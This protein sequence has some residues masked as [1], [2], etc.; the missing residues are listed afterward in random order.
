MKTAAQALGKKLA[1]TKFSQP[2]IPVVH[3][4]DARP[5]PDVP[6]LRSALVKQL[7]S[8]VLWSQ[9]VQYLAE[10]GVTTVMEFGPGKILTGINKRVDKTLQVVCVQDP[11]SMEQALKRCEDLG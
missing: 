2:D 4:V 6:S 1:S 7:H 8:P 11:G 5:H 3:N 9:T 10:Q